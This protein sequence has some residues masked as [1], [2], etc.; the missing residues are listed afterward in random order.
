MLPQMLPQSIFGA[1]D[2]QVK[3]DVNPN[4]IGLPA[5]QLVQQSD[6]RNMVVSSGSALMAPSVKLLP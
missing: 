3:I 2:G 1:T 6:L 5:F 4:F